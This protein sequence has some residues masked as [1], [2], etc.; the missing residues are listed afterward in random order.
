MKLLVCGSRTMAWSLQELVIQHVRELAP[1]QIIEGG[2]KGADTLARLAA[3]FLGIPVQEFPADWQAHGKKAGP[4]RNQ[5]MLDQGP[6]L[7][8]AFHPATGCTPGTAD[9]IRRAQAAGVPVKVVT[10]V[11]SLVV[12]PVPRRGL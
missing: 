12:P 6:D 8:L 9:M 10:Y 4:I 2:A 11:E 3:L 5:Q 1:T 7:V